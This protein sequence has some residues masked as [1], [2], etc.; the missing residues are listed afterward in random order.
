M[1]DTAVT[2]QSDNS[3]T[4][5]VMYVMIAVTNKALAGLPI[6]RLFTFRG[7]KP[8]CEATCRKC[9]YRFSCSIN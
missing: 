4:V 3:V 2:L 5:G 8:G 1:C 7:G 6:P 9:G